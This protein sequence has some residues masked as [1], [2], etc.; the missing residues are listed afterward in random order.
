MVC[1]HVIKHELSVNEL[2][3]LCQGRHL[4]KNSEGESMNR[5]NTSISSFNWCCVMI[6]NRRT[7]LRFWNMIWNNAQTIF[8]HIP[9]TFFL[10]ISI[11]Y[12]SI[13]Y[14]VICS[15]SSRIYMMWFYGF[16]VAGLKYESLHSHWPG[17]WRW[18]RRTLTSKSARLLI[19]ATMTSWP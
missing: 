8:H 6:L 19:L 16:K 4:V 1:S 17:F 11:L 9:S 13:Y 5:R 3:E 10:E 12:Y 2:S 18:A 14:I 7:A 15:Y